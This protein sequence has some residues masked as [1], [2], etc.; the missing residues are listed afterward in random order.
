MCLRDFVW[1]KEITVNTKGKRVMTGSA[2]DEDTGK[3]VPIEVEEETLEQMHMQVMEDAA[4]K[5]A[6]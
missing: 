2:V 6:H 3:L 5:K 1:D 4:K